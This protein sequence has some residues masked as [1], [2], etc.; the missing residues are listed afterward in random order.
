MLLDL[1]FLLDPDQRPTFEMVVSQ[2]TAVIRDMK[3]EVSLRFSH[4]LLQTGREV[5]CQ[6]FKCVVDSQES[7]SAV[8]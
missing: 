2:L 4:W 6:V 5:H 1:C 8:C 3:D 7:H